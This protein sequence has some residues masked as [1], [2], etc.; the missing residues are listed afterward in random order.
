MEK[1]LNML[2]L[3]CAVGIC[4]CNSLWTRN[5]IPEAVKVRFTEMYPT[6]K[7][8][9]WENESETYEARFDVN[10][11]ERTA[12]FTAEGRLLQF[13]EEIQEQYLPRPV[14][15]Q[16]QAQYANF[17]T[18]EAHRV[19]QDNSTYYKVELEQNNRD[20]LLF[21]D[22]SG[23]I[24]EQ[25]PAV[26]EHRSREEA[27]LF[28]FGSYSEVKEEPYGLAEVS[29]ELPSELRE[30][31]GI[32][33][34]KHNLLACVQDEEGTI[35]LYDLGKKEVT[36]RIDFAGPGDYEGIAVVGSTAYVLRSDGAIYEVADFMGK[37]PKTI[38]HASVMAATQNT[39]GLAYDRKNNRLLVAGK[40]YDT[41]L[42]NNKGI[43]AIPLENNKMQAEPVITI[44]L[45]QE[46]L[47]SPGKKQ[48][49]AYDTLQPSSLELNDA[50][51][52]LYILDAGNH[53]MYTLSQQGQ[54][55]KTTMLD[56]K[57]LRQPEGLTFSDTGDIYITTE[58]GKKGKA[59]IMRLPKGA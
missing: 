2:V 1:I 8:V 50:S 47:K 38:L 21:F 13:S 43:Y 48:K 40:G 53:R 28:A 24:L 39:E 19:Q 49:N 26:P 33:F 37:E 15:D 34:L 23:R 11:R 6:A 30:V 58:G 17:N 56:K 59:L 18:E 20:L 10:G 4:A 12:L 51:G 29:W 44:S 42:G 22:S 5:D 55:Q 31:S 54:I 52:E 27:G 35:F 57:Q 16:L 25:Q 7:H 14:L 9:A 3:I 46:Q 36:R 32:S 45:A 41:R